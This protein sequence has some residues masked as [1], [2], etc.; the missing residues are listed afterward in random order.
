[1]KA[2]FINSWHKGNKQCDKTCICIRFGRITLLNISF[3]IS[4]KYLKIIMLNLGVEFN[5]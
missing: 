5:F 2:N 1:M 3:D 4:S